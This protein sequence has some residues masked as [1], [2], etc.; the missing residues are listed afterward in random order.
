[1]ALCEGLRLVSEVQNA[2]NAIKMRCFKGTNALSAVK[3]YWLPPV[4]K[5]S[6]VLN[7]ESPTD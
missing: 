4:T 7:D 1:L 2:L 5:I 6:D 3:K